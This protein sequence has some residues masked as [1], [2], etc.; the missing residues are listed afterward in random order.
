[1][2]TTLKLFQSSLDSLASAASKR[3]HLY[4]RLYVYWA[5]KETIIYTV[6]NNKH[7]YITQ[8]YKIRGTLRRLSF[9]TFFGDAKRNLKLMKKIFCWAFAIL[10]VVCSA[11]DDDDNDPKLQETDRTFII[12]ASEGN[13]AEIEL[14]QLAVTKSTTPGVKE[15]GQMMVTEHQT[16]WDE[17]L[18]DLP[19]RRF[20]RGQV[21]VP[22]QERKMQ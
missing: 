17:L 14:G 15:F 18:D 9:C 16:A 13:L 20:R 6:V 22:A 1:M 21:L 5:Q 3:K 11:C 7:H 2:R 12:N 10:G 19:G 4:D 8:S